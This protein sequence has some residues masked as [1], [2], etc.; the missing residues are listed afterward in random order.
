MKIKES[1]EQIA[2]DLFQ[3]CEAPEELSEAFD[4]EVVLNDDAVG[5]SRHERLNY[6]MREKMWDWLIS[7]LTSGETQFLT[8]TDFPVH[9]QPPFDGCT[10]PFQE[11]TGERQLRI[12]LVLCVSWVI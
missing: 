12:C 8:A 4:A 6:C 5:R 9:I 3:N 1:A 7:V 10:L 11:Y 2:L